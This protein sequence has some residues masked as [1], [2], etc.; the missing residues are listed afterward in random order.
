MANKITAAHINR[1]L[2]KR[3]I[4]ERLV[5]GRGYIYFTDGDSSS[6]ESSSIAV[7]YVADIVQP[8]LTATVDRVLSE[9]NELRGFSPRRTV[10]SLL[11]RGYG[12]IDRMD[13]TDAAYVHWRDGSEQL[14]LL[15][16]LETLR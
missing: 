14:C 6:W 7:C 13:G 8:T 10:H 16:D 4:S 11:G 9:R 1:E 5:Q 12:R 2:K 15:T 3:G